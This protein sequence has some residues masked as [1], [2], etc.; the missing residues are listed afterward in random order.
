M[1]QVRLEL[2]NKFNHLQTN[3]FPW[4]QEE[5]GPLS[6]KQKLFVE[7]LE[8][9]QIETFIPYSPKEPG[10]PEMNRI[11]VA[12]AFV[13]KAIFN[14]PTTKFLL[15][16]LKSSPTI[17]RLCGW[18][19]YSDIPSESTF[20]RAF[21]QFSDSQ[22]PERLHETLIGEY[23]KNQLIGHI[24]RDSTAIIARE[25]PEKSKPKETV[26]KKR[27]RPKK[28]EER[29][30]KALTRLENQSRGMSIEA[31]IEDLPNACNVGTK[32]NS[33]GFQN[34]WI[35]YKLHIDCTESGIPISCLLTSASLH[36]SQVAIP[37][38]EISH[39]R[40]TNCYDLMDAA[41]CSPLIDAH[42]RSLGHIPIIDEN[43]RRDKERKKEIEAE[44]KAQRAAGYKTAE[45]VRYN[46]RS[47][48]ERVNG[49]LKDDL[50]GRVV[51][52][53]GAKKVM[54]HLMFGIVALAASQL[55]S[56]VQL[57]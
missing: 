18:E 21:N 41:Y 28:G 55:L 50:G 5:L 56:L 17:R 33:K 53:K 36:D 42:S 8:L 47:S 51:R 26:K 6:K 4:L 16:Y 44:T 22:L 11:A 31:M 57:E 46:E 40:V 12:R 23:L 20:S 2:S 25:K 54:A 1:N 3:L 35:G 29:P 34:T 27:G 15:D 49:R 30:E 7:T 32:R 48:V 45:V 37:L 39:K 13:A 10:R 52:V 19:R 38:A 43:P 24:S 14:M 9:I